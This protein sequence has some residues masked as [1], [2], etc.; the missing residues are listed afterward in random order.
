MQNSLLFAATVLI[1][2]TTW[3]AIAWQIGTVDLVVSVFY[4][5]GLAGLIFVLGLAALGRL[6]KPKTWRFVILQAFCLFSFNF[7]CFYQATFFM[8]SGLVSVIFSLATI[9]NAVNA[10]LFFGENLRPRTLVAGIIGV[11]G[12]VLLF[13]HDLTI[14]FDVNVLLGMA[15]ATAGTVFFSVGNM[16]SRKNTQH[17]VTP[18]IANAWGMCIGA[19]ILLA[20]VILRQ[21]P[22]TLPP[23]SSYVWALLYLALVGSVV[24]FTTYLLLV[25][26]LGSDRAAYTTVL[27]PVVALLMSTL[28]EGYQWHTTS[29]LG[30]GLTILG[31]LVMFSKW[32]PRRGFSHA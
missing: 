22:L 23:T 4:R 19:L 32:H 15:W 30:V 2:G 27:F 29:V 31:N 1:W 24:G 21:A 20:L 3:I 25:A 17:G 18:I 7:I 26:R 11:L 12:L 14:S 6:E 10:R 8:P 28:F 13:W 9:F 5:F 16:M